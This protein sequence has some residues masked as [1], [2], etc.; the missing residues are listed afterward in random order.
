MACVAHLEC[1]PSTTSAT[2]RTACYRSYSPWQGNGTQ[3]S[4]VETSSRAHRA[5]F[6]STVSRG[7]RL[8]GIRRARGCATLRR[9]SAGASI[10][11]P[12]TL[13]LQ[14]K[15]AVRS[16][17][18]LPASNQRPAAAPAASFES[19]RAVFRAATATA[20]VNRSASLR[21]SAVGAP[22]CPYTRWQPFG[23]Q[24]RRTPWP[25]PNPFLPW[26]RGHGRGVSRARYEAEASRRHQGPASVVRRRR[27]PPR[28]L[29][30]RSRSPRLAESSEHRRDLRAR[31]RR[32]TSPR[33]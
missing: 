3:R 26:G 16:P 30:A 10:A 25:V 20:A 17:S 15:H 23:P 9:C 11:P 5:P 7:Q 13:R 24:P 8:M 27:R 4:C 14:V 21:S 18:W 31:G 28:A 12:G 32:R 33:S 6:V 22:P 1:V 2:P 19:C 29:S